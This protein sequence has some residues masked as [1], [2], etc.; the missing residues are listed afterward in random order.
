MRKVMRCGAYIA[1]LC[2]S[3]VVSG[4]MTSPEATQLLERARRG[5]AE[6]QFELAMRYG[7]GEGVVQNEKEAVKWCRLAADQGFAEAQYGLGRYYEFSEDKDSKEAGKWYRLAAEQGY[8]EAQFRLG[9]WYDPTTNMFDEVANEHGAAEEAFKWFKL[10]AEQEHSG[11]QISLGNCYAKGIGVQKDHKEAAKWFRRAFE[12]GDEYAELLWQGASPV[13][14]YQFKAE[15]GDAKYQYMVGVQYEVGEDLSGV[16]VDHKEAVKWYRLAADQ[17]YAD[18]QF[19]LG[20]CY[21]NGQ[22]VWEDGKEAVKW[23]QLAAEQG[24]S[25]A[26]CNLGVCY[27]HGKGVLEDYVEAYAWFVI[28][29]MNGDSQGAENKDILKNK[30]NNLQIAA[31]QERAKELI[32]NIER[33]KQVARLPAGEVPSADIAPSGFGSGL[34]VKDG[35]VVTCWHVVEN[36]KKISINCQ[37]K[38][39][40]ASVVQKDVGNDIAILCVD[41]ADAGALL[42]V[43]DSVKLGSQVFTMGFPHPGLQGSD[44]KFTTGSISGLTGPKNTPV[45]YQISAPLQS[46]NSGGPLFDEYGN[47]VG[48]VAAK[49]DSLKMLAATGDLTQN[50]NYAIKVDYLVPLLKTVDGIKIQPSQTK[51]VNLLSLVEELKKSVV[52]IKVY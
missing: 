46:G 22:G 3:A 5:D 35:Y 32:A 19:S 7:A 31:G 26:Q 4:E 16:P 50:V 51:P 27:S 25:G 13:E 12:Q 1:I 37:G 41:G 29:A 24:D 47:L 6:A 39:F 9:V 11:A 30:L 8:A 21:G 40:N 52:M 44:V 15:Q 36:S 42:S 38:D 33:K 18:A 23:Y 43:A 2:L 28:A 14:Y 34:L 17:G 20:R 49:L 48:I 45:Y 10:A